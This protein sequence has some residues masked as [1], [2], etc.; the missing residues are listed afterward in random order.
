MKTLIQTISL[1]MLFLLTF[2][3]PAAADYFDQNG[4]KMDKDQYEKAVQMRAADTNKINK[5]GYSESSSRLDDPVRLRN[6]RIDQW[7]SYRNKSRGK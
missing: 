2:S 1:L 5:D 7:K 3:T 6:K 4:V